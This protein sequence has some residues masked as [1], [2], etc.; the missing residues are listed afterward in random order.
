MIMK[1]IKTLS[2]RGKIAYHTKLRV[3]FDLFYEASA[4]MYHATDNPNGKF[5]LNT[6][7]NKQ[8]WHLLKD[9]IELLGLEKSIPD[10]VPNYTSCL[11]HESFRKTI[12]GFLTRF[13]AKC[14]INPDH[15]AVSAGA[16]PLIELS[17]WLLGDAGDVA[18][19]PT[20]S[21]PVYKQDIGN[22]SGMERYNLITH[23]EL[24]EISE[25]PILKIKQLKKAKKELEQLGKKFKVL[26]LTTPDNP[27]GGTYTQK[28]LDKVSNWC[29]QNRIHLIVN[30]IYGLSILDTKHPAIKKDYQKHR[31]FVSFA[32]MMQAK[33]SPY[34]HFWY[35][36]SKDF[37]IS[38]FRVGLLYSLNEAFIKAYDN[39]NVP[40]LV[41]NHTQ[42][43]LSEIMA[44]HDFMEKY[45]THNQQALTESYVFMVKQL[46][47]LE[48]PY[49]PSRGSLFIWID[50]F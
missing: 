30:E 37:G 39:V 24:S 44:D 35:A 29:I 5:P 40:H 7:E 33:K 1:N 13:L 12:A 27:T 10:W 17:T 14:P 2:K 4:D 47:A 18:V 3:D 32:P 20:P 45:I 42:W 15:L 26:V 43:L 36:L 25:K 22:K 41:S 19:F 50:C 9:R 31:K 16:T 48:I 34:L 8:S 6:A 23:H 21:Y 38:G 11:G 49:V 46:R 28:Q